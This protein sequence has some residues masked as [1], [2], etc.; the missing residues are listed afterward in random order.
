[1]VWSLV[2]I[3]IPIQAGHPDKTN[4]HK[5]MHVQ[6][7]PLFNVATLLYILH[8]NMLSGSVIA[9]PCI[10]IYMCAHAP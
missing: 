3:I 8:E 4:I 10:S 9:T 5:I 2:V 1:M 6:I 7:F